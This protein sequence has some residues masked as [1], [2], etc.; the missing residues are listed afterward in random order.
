M[1]QP[2]IRGLSDWRS[3]A[4][5]SLTEIWE[6]RQLSLDRR[7][8]VKIYGPARVEADHGFLREV[9]AAGRLSSHPSIVTV[10]DAGILADD[11]LYL[12]MEQCPGGSLQGRLDAQHRLG[13]EGVR[14]FGV[15]IA[16]ALAAAHSAGIVHG[17]VMPAN[18]LIDSYGNARLTDFGRAIIDD[19]AID[20]PEVAQPPSDYRPPE[21][22][23]RQPATEPGDVFSLAATLCALLTGTAPARLGRI[24]EARDGVAERAMGQLS[25]D[26]LGLVQPLL[27]ALDPNP[28]LRPSAAQFRDQ[29]HEASSSGRSAGPSISEPAA[30]PPSAST[31]ESTGSPSSKGSRAAAAGAAVRQGSMGKASPAEVPSG[32]LRRRAGVP[33]LAAAAFAVL[34]SAGI[35]LI[36][37]SATDRAAPVTPTV[38][39]TTSR[40]ADPAASVQATP[41][42]GTNGTGSSSVP[43]GKAIELEK[44]ALSAKPF[45]VVQVR[46]TYAGGAGVFL[47]AQRREKG[48]WIS[49]PMPAKSDEAGRFTLF[50]ELDQPGRY[51]LRAIDPGSGIA[52]APFLV[53]VA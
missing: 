35:W 29:L 53:T 31:A 34:A 15:Q 16:D 19:A 11:R 2:Q 30:E 22:S 47:S 17:G 24:T 52:S 27:S 44:P 32:R 21:A 43:A 46:G 36:S 42:P 37:E 48:K 49:F 7:V 4:H 25:A 14:R 33:A 20:T 50:V 41:A 51:Q 6:A 39:A 10:Y 1:E 23:D 45:Q 5:G 3:L 8:A 13:A 18:I 38:A 12:I 26:A 28:T 9:A 40:L